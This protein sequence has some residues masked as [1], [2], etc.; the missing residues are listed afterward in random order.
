MKMFFLKIK[1]WQLF[2]LILLLPLFLH[3]LFFEQF[4]SKNNLIT[5]NVIFYPTSLIII[6]FLLQLWLFS[7]GMTL[8]EYIPKEIRRRKLCYYVITLYPAIFLLISLPATLYLELKN[9]G[10]VNPNPFIFMI[11]LLFAGFALFSLLFGLQLVAR[12]IKSYEL[13]RIARFRDY[14]KE[15]LYLLIFPIGFLLIQPRI[16]AINRSIKICT[17]EE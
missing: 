10:G 16:N 12:G 3:F 17:L 5:G 13:Q 8:N 2:G 15:F 4:G 7:I 14:W 6:V 11:F 1:N 9:L